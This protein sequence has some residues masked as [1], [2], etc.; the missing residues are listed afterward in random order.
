MPVSEFSYVPEEP[1]PN[2]GGLNLGKPKEASLPVSLYLTYSLSLYLSLSL[3]ELH[4][5]AITQQGDS[6][7]PLEQPGGWLL[8]SQRPGETTALLGKSRKV[9]EETT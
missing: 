7:R 9:R 5:F 8:L 4:I 2:H 1:C 6:A 3:C